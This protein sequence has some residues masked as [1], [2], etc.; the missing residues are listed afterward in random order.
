MSRPTKHKLMNYLKFCTLQLILLFFTTLVLAQ[1]SSPAQSINKEATGLNVIVSVVGLN[2]AETKNAFAYLDI[3]KNKASPRLNK[4]WLKQLHSKAE[5]DIKKSLHAFGYYQASIKSQLS[6]D[7]NGIWHATYHIKTGKKVSYTNV[8]IKISGAG[9]EEKKIIAAQENFNIKKG[10][11]LDHEF[12]ETSKTDLLSLIG[13]LGYADA[14]IEKKQ[15]LINPE[16]NT[17]ELILHISTGEKFYLGEFNFHQDILK[18]ELLNKY[19][20]DIKRGEFYSQKN[21]LDIQQSLVRSG[22]FSLVDIEPKFEQAEEQHVPIDISLSPVKQHKFS[23]GIGFDTEIDL[24]ASARWQNRLINSSGHNSDVLLK[25]SDKQS[26]LQGTYWIPINDPRTDKL[27]FISRFETEDTGSTYRKTLDLE[28][29]YIFKWQQWDAKLFT[30]L[31]YEQYEFGIFDRS[32]SLLSLGARMDGNFIETR[33]YPRKGWALY[34]ELRG[35]PANAL[36]DTSYM[37]VHVKSRIIFPV[38]DGGRL[39]LR[40]E[41]GAATVDKVLNYPNSLRFFAGGDQSVRGYDW[42]SLGPTDLQGDVIGGRNVLT[43]SIEYNHKVNKSWVAAAF[44]D[45]G[46]AFNDEIDKI[47]YGAGFGARWISPVG[48]VRLDLGIPINGDDEVTNLQSAV[49]YF[50]FEISL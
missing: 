49:L 5:K 26:K 37:R 11:L 39:L 31:K 32:S 50:G 35:A 10:D 42:K 46:N 17:V 19:L 23:F 15:L 18:P 44:F 33:P 40:G 43:A 27:G 25:I 4:L 36:S 13:N 14:K 1:E 24:N 47:Y 45:A 16:E 28:A 2:K 6:K 9:N 30:E 21:L 22:F 8:E 29:N 7:T 12:Y 41:V 38:M 48:L 34:T 20:V 3:E